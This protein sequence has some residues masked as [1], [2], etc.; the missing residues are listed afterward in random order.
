MY[1]NCPCLVSLAVRIHIYLF[2]VLEL[3]INPA[4]NSSFIDECSIEC[5]EDLVS[6]VIFFF[7]MLH[8]LIPLLP[9]KNRAEA[10][11]PWRR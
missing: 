9:Q 3:S 4:F 11:A 2:S 1:P 10:A 7:S 5:K 8:L 6:S